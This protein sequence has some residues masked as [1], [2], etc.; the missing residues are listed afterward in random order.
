[1]SGQHRYSL[2][3][4]TSIPLNPIVFD[5]KFR[6]L[7]HP[8]LALCGQDQEECRRQS[9][10]F[11]LFTVVAMTALGGV[12]GTVCNATQYQQSLISQDSRSP[13]ISCLTHWE[14][15]GL[16]VSILLICL[17]LSTRLIYSSRSNHRSLVASVSPW[18]F[19]GYVYARL[20]LVWLSC[21]T[22]YRTAKR[23][24]V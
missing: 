1:M 3:L 21:L 12:N 24:L 6:I 20:P 18:Q 7:T 14:I 23:T 8:P 15:I 22:K 13:S 2:N 9:L 10:L 11:S 5:R 4:G 16:V 19:S 17:R